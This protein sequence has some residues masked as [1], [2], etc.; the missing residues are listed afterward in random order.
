MIK[1]GR[2]LQRYLQRY[3]EY[4]SWIFRNSDEKIYYNTLLS[5]NKL[6]VSGFRVTK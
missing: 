1:L 4:Q 3:Q 6:L 2:Q 5:N